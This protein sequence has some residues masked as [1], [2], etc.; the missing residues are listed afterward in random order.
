MIEKKLVR[1]YDKLYKHFGP[2]EWWPA[3]SSFEVA[4]G[5]I[6][7]QNT[8]WKNVE[9]AMENLKNAHA[10]SFRR[11]SEMS[12]GKLA[13]LIKPAGYYNIKA[14]RLKNF[15]NFLKKSYRGSLGR[16][17]QKNTALAREELLCVNGIGEETADS[18]LLYALG[19][20]VFVVDA[21]TRRISSRHHLINGHL[22]YRQI[23]RFFMDR[24]PHQT[25]LFNE[26]HALLV[27]CGKEFCKKKES[28]CEECP[29]R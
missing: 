18:I 2:Q 17:K 4:I 10:L 24:L 22:D 7:T 29:L 19:K 9:R 15:L 5:A 21:Y 6:L 28:N 14:K 16:M 12:A 27:R 26:Y 8:S 13:G 23:Q 3:D 1:I 25:V 20:P 11:M